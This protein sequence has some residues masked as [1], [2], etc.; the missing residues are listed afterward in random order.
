MKKINEF[1]GLGRKKILELTKEYFKSERI[2]LLRSCGFI[3]LSSQWPFFS[4][5]NGAI[6]VFI[7]FALYTVSSLLSYLDQADR[8]ARRIKA[9]RYARKHKMAEAEREYHYSTKDKK[10]N[11]K[12]FSF[13]IT[14]ILFVG[15]VVSASMYL[16]WKNPDTY[17]SEYSSFFEGLFW[18]TYVV[19][20]FEIIFPIVP[21]ILINIYDEFKMSRMFVRIKLIINF[22][23]VVLGLGFF[24]CGSIAYYYFHE[25]ENVP[26]AWFRKLVSIIYILFNFIP[27]VK[28]IIS[29]LNKR[30]RVEA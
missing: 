24:L 1:S 12:A 8:E 16:Q 29:S 18:D 14:S 13:A 23:V 10:Y 7:W 30:K 11:M 4:R 2:A 5:L 19:A 3:L 28:N 25:F 20:L 9:E 27:Y 26:F 15:F 17:N 21:V 6:Y 22:I